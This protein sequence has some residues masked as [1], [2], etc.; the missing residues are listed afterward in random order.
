MLK[1]LLELAVVLSLCACGALAGAVCL[2]GDFAA[3]VRQLTG[4]PMTSQHPSVTRLLDDLRGT[5][6]RRWKEFDMTV[7]GSIPI[8]LSM[9]LSDVDCY[10]RIPNYN[11]TEHRHVVEQ[12]VDLLRQQPNLYSDVRLVDVTDNEKDVYFTFWHIP[13][14]RTGEIVFT[15][16]GAVENSNLL[17]YLFRLDKLNLPLG[18][19]IKY[20]S[21]VHELKALET[22]DKLPSYAWYIMTVFYLQQK[23]LAPSVYELQRRTD[24]NTLDWDMSFQPI[25]F[26]VRN[27]QSLYQLLGGFFQYYSQFDFQYYIVSPFTGRPIQRNDFLNIDRVPE[28]FTAYK[29]IALNN[30]SCCQIELNTDLCIQNIFKHV[31]NVAN[32]ISHEEA[33][34]ILSHIK[35]AAQM[36]EELPS[37]RFLT[38]IL[39]V[40]HRVMEGNEVNTTIDGSYNNCTDVSDIL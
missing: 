15:Q 39:N 21:T 19:I 30:S 22:M 37:D 5:L 8:G 32:L 35:W 27:N 11:I 23:G 7:Y 31:A 18:R 2:A 16:T 34:R 26:P 9:K 25:P 10:V 36:Y 3:Q 12:A 4:S 6:N 40:R 14:Q 28:E 38:T 20:W 1:Y 24:S 33:F 29:N 17:S 13:T